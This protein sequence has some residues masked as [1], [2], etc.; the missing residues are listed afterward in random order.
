MT[1]TTKTTKTSW[2]KAG[3]HEGVTLPSGTVVSIRLPNLSLM[4]KT[5]QIPNTLVEAAVKMQSL[6]ASASPEITQEM[7]EQQWDYSS[8][9]VAA[10]VVEPAITQDEVAEIP[11]EDVEMLVEFATRQRDMDAAYRHIGGLD[12][13]D[14]FRRFRGV[15]DSYEDLED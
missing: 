11:T 8:F 5:G 2:K 6:E 14:S 3:I 12:K 9:L 7:I 1:S 4:M 10:T 13:L 15:D